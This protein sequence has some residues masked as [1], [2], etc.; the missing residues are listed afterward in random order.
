VIGTE[1]WSGP[2]GW[3]LIGFLVMAA[4]WT[5]V[6]VVVIGLVRGR[7][8]PGLGGSTAALHTLEERYARGE[9]DRDEFVERRAVLTGER[10]P[11]AQPPTEPNPPAT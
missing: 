3:G 11:P 4:F 2:G 8:G 6:I 9:I 10:P 5:V 1:F 7:R